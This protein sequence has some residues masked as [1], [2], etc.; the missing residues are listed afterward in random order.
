MPNGDCYVCRIKADGTAMRVI[1]LHT[2]MDSFAYTPSCSDHQ[3]T[4]GHCQRIGTIPNIQ[5]RK[6][7]SFTARLW[8]DN[9]GLANDV[10]LEA[11]LKEQGI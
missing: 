10:T 9:S 1:P 5:E 4:G 11:K 3:D 8:T 6:L 7:R 2:V